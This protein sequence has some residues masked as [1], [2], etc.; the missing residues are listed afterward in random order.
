VRAQP[1]IPKRQTGLVAEGGVSKSLDNS[2]RPDAATRKQLQR[3]GGSQ[4]S[5]S[6]VASGP[7]TTVDGVWKEMLDASGKVYY[8]HSECVRRCAAA[9][10]CG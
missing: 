4:M 1:F 8:V 6:E 9:S 7:P 2:P 10:C 5:Y 3:A